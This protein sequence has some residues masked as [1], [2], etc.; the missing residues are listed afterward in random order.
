MMSGRLADATA[1]VLGL[2]LVTADDRL[3]RARG[4]PALANQ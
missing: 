3:L 1:K 4:V 2:T